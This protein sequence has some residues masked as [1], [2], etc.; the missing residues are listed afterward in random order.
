MQ[1]LPESVPK[2]RKVELL[3]KTDA[4]A[5]EH[6]SA[7]TQVTV[8][9]SEGRRKVLVANTDGVRSGRPNSNVAFPES[10]L[11]A[12]KV[13]KPGAKQLAT[14]LGLSYSMTM[15]LKPWHNGP[16][17]AIT[18]LAARPAP[19]GNFVVIERGGGG[20]LFHEACGHGSKLTLSTRSIRI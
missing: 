6:D 11:A 13:C 14:R 7:I 3:Q 4:A 18:K 12:T 8:R 16:P 1:I 19:S 2:A 17:D 20:V 10:L 9:Y 15:T 5:R